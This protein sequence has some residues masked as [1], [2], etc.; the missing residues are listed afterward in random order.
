MKYPGFSLPFVNLYFLA[1]YIAKICLV[2]LRGTHVITLCLF[3]TNLTSVFY[4]GNL[5]LSDVLNARLGFTCFIC[6][7]VDHN[8]IRLLNK[9]GSLGSRTDSMVKGFPLRYK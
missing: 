1:Y 8:F 3:E 2:E 5:I 4:V 6:L 9:R 7:V